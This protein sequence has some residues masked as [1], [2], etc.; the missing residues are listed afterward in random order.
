MAAVAC[1]LAQPI[2]VT[3]FNGN[4]ALAGSFEKGLVVPPPFLN[5]QSVNFPTA[6][7]ERL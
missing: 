7:T 4:A 6:A 3:F 1:Q 2:L 5:P